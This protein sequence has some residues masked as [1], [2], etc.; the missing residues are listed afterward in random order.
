[1]SFREI[2]AVCFEIHMKHINTLC[3]EKVE[4]LMWD[5]VA[6]T[7]SKHEDFKE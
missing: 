6:R 7:N 2:H 4:I 1:M 5:V 3:G